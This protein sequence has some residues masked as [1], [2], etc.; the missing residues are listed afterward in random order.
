MAEL[1]AGW[2]EQTDIRFQAVI[3]VVEQPLL[4]DP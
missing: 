4:R 3:L 1:I 2:S